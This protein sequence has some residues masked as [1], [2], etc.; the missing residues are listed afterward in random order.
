MYF[1]LMLQYKCCSS[2]SNIMI[3]LNHIIK[4]V[5]I[6]F[7]VSTIKYLLHP[8]PLPLLHHWKVVDPPPASSDPPPRVSGLC[9]PPVFLS[10]LWGLGSG[11]CLLSCSLHG[12]ILDKGLYLCRNTGYV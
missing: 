1:L 8:C 9:L 6:S 11:I 3:S 12:Q 2:C 10:L 7:K 5:L 4:S